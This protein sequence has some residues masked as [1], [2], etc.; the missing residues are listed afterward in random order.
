MQTIRTEVTELLQAWND[1]D[2]H[3]RDQLFP[4]IFDDLKAIARCHY[5][6]EDSS[7]TLQPTAIVNEL[8]LKLVR[9]RQVS[10]ADRRGF[11]AVASE[12]MRR[13]L[14]D[15]ARKRLAA[16]RGGDVPR[17][18][19]NDALGLHA[20]QDEVL[21]TLDEGLEELAQEDPRGQRVVELHVFGGLTF[22]EIALSLKVT[23]RTVMRDWKH[24]RLWL[25]RF[26]KQE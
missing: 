20:V 19:F 26:L 18:V 1:G 14:V 5:S 21:V 11:F 9:Q 13:I 7:H 24:A 16:R 2:A 17:L 22:D 25:R 3:A 15:H 8:Y 12:L 23:R 10:W 4:L 6:H